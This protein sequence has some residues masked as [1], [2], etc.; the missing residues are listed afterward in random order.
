MDVGD[1]VEIVC[2]CGGDHG[3][4][5]PAAYLLVART[6]YDLGATVNVTVD[7]VGAW[8]VPRI[9]IGMHGLKSIE[10]PA[11]AERYGWERVS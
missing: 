5:R 8:R 6:V 4:D 7:G 3:L 10:L 1:C 11:L 9:W 2:P